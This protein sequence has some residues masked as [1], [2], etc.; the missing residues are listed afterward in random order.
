MT[1]L[2]SGRAARR[3]TTKAALASLYTC[4]TP[5]QTLQYT[6]PNQ[7]TH[8]QYIHYGKE[9]YLSTVSQRRYNHLV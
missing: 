4:L 9:R 5:I 2:P 3:M 1:R 8:L 6:K 7:P